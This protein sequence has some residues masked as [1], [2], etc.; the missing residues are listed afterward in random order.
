MLRCIKFVLDSK[1]KGLLIWPSRIANEPWDIICYTD[2][3]YASDPETRRSVSGYI[4]YVHGVPVCFR[5][6]A[7]RCVTLSSCEAEWIALSEAVKDV[8]F[9]LH[10]CEAMFITIKLPVTVR[11]DN[12]GAIFMTENVTTS[13]N[14]RHVDIRSRWLKEYCENGTVKIIFVR[15]E[16]NVSDIVTEN[17]SGPLHSKHAGVLVGSRK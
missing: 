4:I 16:N 12:V 3:D 7:Q 14:T 1:T 2:S 5:S 8:I 9:L 10:L 13:N 11:V 17:L 6:K 15:S